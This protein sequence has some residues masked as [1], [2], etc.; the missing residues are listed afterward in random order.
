M[1]RRGPAWI[2]KKT[3]Q[4]LPPGS[5]GARFARGTFW[6]FL[7]TTIAQG[8]GMV[9]SIV[10]A[11]L[12]GT[13]GFGEYGM[14]NSTVGTFGV[15]AGLGL[16][17]TATKYI[18]E[19]RQTD[20]VRAG[21]IL[22]LS[23]R[24]AM[25]SSGLVAL[26]LLVISPW[27]ATHTLNASHLDKGLALGCLL[28]FFNSLNGV[29]AGA[30]GGFEAFKT[31][32][33]VNFLRGVL[34]FPLMLAGVWFFG[35]M[36]AISAQVLVS[37]A[38]WWLNHRAIRKECDRAGISRH[39]GH[40]RTEIST[41]WTFAFPAFLSG[42]VVGPFL[43]L[44]NTLLVNQPG[45][46]GEL[47]L[48]SVANQW[49][50]VLMLLPGIFNSVALPMLSSGQENSVHF[51]KTLDISQS[52][53][54]MIILPVATALLLGNRWI[55]MLYGPEYGSGGPVF[56]SLL[57]GVAIAGIGS[58]PG[59]AIQATGRMWLGA[60]LNLTWGVALLGL[61][62]LLVP[63]WGGFGLALAFALAYIFLTLWSYIY[64]LFRQ[65]ASRDM[66][67]RVFVGMAFLI[68][69]ALLALLVPE[70]LAW[71]LIP[72]VVLLGLWLALWVLPAPFVRQRVMSFLKAGKPVRQEHVYP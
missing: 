52:L 7:G 54:I 11:R 28:L 51:E 18:A 57:T 15:F 1:I 29:Q 61:A 66:F 10:T 16:G 71:I 43:W 19:Y 65:L 13:T 63:R 33:K 22:T 69:V 64:L 32:A 35:L 20:P 5:L 2:R 50:A 34:N 48:L 23:T 40:L 62:A 21:R 30:L 60:L 47:G 12:L 59:S 9:A 25:I 42:I 56:V 68:A 45:G 31:I 8:L 3:G 36:G 72:P 49:R 53:S 6:A 26:I 55:M 58:S 14:I 17:L 24:A 67:I 37:V 41:L 39:G 70:Q 27:L 4:L 46:Y 38:G 44:S